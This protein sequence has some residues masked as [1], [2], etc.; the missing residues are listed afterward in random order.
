MIV[1]KLSKIYQTKN[2]LRTQFLYVHEIKN[3][4]ISNADNKIT[5]CNFRNIFIH[6]NI[7]SRLLPPH[8]TT[9][10]SV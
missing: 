10:T 7:Y 6:S 4:I 3:Q 9:I 5:K 2:Q 8:W 1:K